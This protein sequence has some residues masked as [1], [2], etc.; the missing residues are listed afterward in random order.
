MLV[1]AHTT[2]H[3]AAL[4]RL[5]TNYIVLIPVSNSGFE[6]NLADNVRFTQVLEQAFRDILY[7]FTVDKDDFKQLFQNLIVL[8]KQVSII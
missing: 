8:L 5:I 1:K 6:N 2:F 3:L 7:K 4:L